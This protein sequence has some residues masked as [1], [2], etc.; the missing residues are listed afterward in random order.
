MYRWIFIIKINISRNYSLWQGD[1]TS[2]NCFKLHILLKK[3]YTQ[4]VSRLMTILSSQNYLNNKYICMYVYWIYW[5]ILQSRTD[6]T[7]DWSMSIGP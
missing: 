5:N 6:L 3:N 7:E 4:H 1:G 2:R